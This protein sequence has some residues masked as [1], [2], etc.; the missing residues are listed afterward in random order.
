MIYDNVKFFCREKGI[1]I[2]K[3]ETVLEFPRSS[4]CKWNENEPGIRKVQKVADYLNVSI[5]ELLKNN[6]KEEEEA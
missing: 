5:E 3:L 4:I 1:T 6:Q 2:S